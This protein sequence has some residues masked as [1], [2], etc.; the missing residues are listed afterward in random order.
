MRRVLL[1]RHGN[2]FETG[3]PVVRVGARSDLPL[4]SKGIEQAHMFGRAVREAE[5]AVG[6]YAAGPLARTREFVRHAFGIRPREDDRL[7]EID[8]GRWEGLTDAQIAASFGAEPL[9]A[10]NKRCVWPE[11]EN[12]SP[13]PAS[14]ERGA[15][16]LLAEL[17]DGDPAFAPVL[18]SSQGILRYFGRQDVAWFADAAA[19]GNLGVGT[20]NCCGIELGGE[21]P[22]V[23]FWNM[24]PDAASLRGWVSVR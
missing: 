10:W 5:L 9:E 16:A 8:Y 11:G 17:R 7:R 18:C 22:R 6:P 1:V 2:T 3:A 12:W 15:A 4:T 23:A 21:S 13:D 20:G 14:L 19:E 24:K